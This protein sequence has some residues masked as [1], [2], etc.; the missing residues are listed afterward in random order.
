MSEVARIVRTGHTMMERA[1]Q[2]G[3]VT[4]GHEIM[5]NRREAAIEMGKWGNAQLRVWGHGDTL[6]DALAAAIEK[7]TPFAEHF[8]HPDRI[9]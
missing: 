5:S 9:R 7:A 4:T 3:R 6:D 1:E 8:P 2:F